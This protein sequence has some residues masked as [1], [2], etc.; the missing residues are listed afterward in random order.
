VADFAAD[1]RRYLDDEPIRARPAGVGE[2]LWKWVRRHRAL[3]IALGIALTGPVFAVLGQAVPA[4]AALILGLLGTS[5][6]L[7]R[8]RRLRRE[9]EAERRIARREADKANAINEFLQQMLAS[10]HSGEHGHDVKVT[11]LLDQAADRLGESFR[12]QPEVEGPLR[13]TL[14]RSYLGLARHEA[15]QEQLELAH[16]LCTRALGPGNLD[17]LNALGWLSIALSQQGRHAEAEPLQ[18]RLIELRRRFL[19]EDHPETLVSIGQMSWIL[20]AL[21]RKDEAIRTQ[22]SA[23]DGLARTRGAEHRDTVVARGLLASLL[24]NNDEFEEAEREFRAAIS[25]MRE[26]VPAGSQDLLASLSNFATAL[27][28]QQKLGEAE[29]VYLEV[30]ETQ[31]KMLGEDHPHLWLTASQYARLLV[32]TDRADEGEAMLRR[33]VEV[34]HDCFGE[35]HPYAAQAVASHGEALT[36]LGRLDEAE[37]LLRRSVTHSE[38]RR[39]DLAMCHLGHCLLRQGR[40]D[41]AQEVLQSGYRGMREH[42][43]PGN[44]ILLQAEAD[45]AELAP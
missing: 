32:H 44:A 28:S 36:V 25:A 31:R 14:G 41:E 23:V 26:I 15:A 3:V 7:V 20:R 37:T 34:L 1:L 29:P 17:S 13:L 40:R 33:S 12:S 21:G 2:R 4:Y 45:L 22:R 27:H 35:A 10:V 24:G 16:E 8:S 9:A 39:R 43:S 19:G 42:Y 30:M 38:G 11:D 18:A 6:G 5:I